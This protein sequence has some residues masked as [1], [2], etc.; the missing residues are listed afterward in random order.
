MRFWVYEQSQGGGS[1]GW[2]QTGETRYL[3]DGMNVVQERDG[4]DTPAVTYT[5]RFNRKHRMFGHLFSGRYKAL[6]VDG[7]TS[8]YLKSASDYV[9]LNPARAHLIPVDQPLQS[10][11]W[12]SYPLYLKEPAQRPAWLRTDRL[13][14][15]WGIPMDT[16]A[17][18]EQFAA[19]LEARRRAEEAQGVEPPP[20]RGWCVGSEQFRQELLDQM[21]RLPDHQYGGPEWQETC[22]RKAERI[23][24]EELR[25]RGWDLAELE[26]RRKGDAEKVIIARRLRAET[27][28]TWAW[29]SARLNM[30]A[31]GSAA[32]RLRDSNL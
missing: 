13:L 6:P 10:Y 16:T 2:N 7:S 17:G 30:G 18:R 3:Y 14:G 9:H 20:P 28:M 4:A 15:E 32:N 25:Q 1:G 23:L 26:R 29:V 27:T 12:S 11:R 22:E 21:T 5:S 24:A 31:A 19:R 8:G